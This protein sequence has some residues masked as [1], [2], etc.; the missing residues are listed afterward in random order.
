[1]ARLAQSIL[2]LEVLEDIT[3]TQTVARY[4]VGI[5]RTDTLSRRTHLALTLGSLVGSVEHTMGWH[6]EMS[7]ARDV[8]A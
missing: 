8:K 6:D 5:G 7:L 1:M 3:N 2:L 4:L